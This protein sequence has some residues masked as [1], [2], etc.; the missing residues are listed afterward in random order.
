MADVPNVALC[1]SS[2]IIPYIIGDKQ[3]TSLLSFISIGF[4]Y[5]EI[6]LRLNVE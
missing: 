5:L 3:S 2:G 4:Y 6:V 1:M